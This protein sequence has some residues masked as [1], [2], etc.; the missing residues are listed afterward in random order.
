[1]MVMPI[2]CSVMREVFSQVPSGER[3]GRV[4]PRRDPV[5][6][7]PHRRPALRAGRDHRRDDARPGPGPRRDDRR[8]P[9]HLA[10]ASRSTS[11]SSR[12]AATRCRA[13][14]RCATR[15]RPGSAC[16]RSW[17]PGWRCS[18]SLS[19]STSP[20]RCSSP[21]HARDRAAKHDD[22]R[23][24]RAETGAAASPAATTTDPGSR[25]R[26]AGRPS[27]RR[28]LGAG[29]ARRPDE[30]RRGAG[31]RALHHAAALRA[32]HVAVGPAWVRRR[33]LRRLPRRR[34]PSCV[35]LTDDR[36]AVVDKLMTTLFSTAAA[37]AGLA[38]CSPSSPSP[39]GGAGR[40]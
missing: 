14:S 7:D 12:P 17:P 5:G 40:R 36:P 4:R 20:R 24:T 26:T 25:D 16:R 1:M 27:V 35:S 31:E 10:R 33:H 29:L 23:R 13:S 18:P 2:Q 3:E 11:T 21:G 6:D 19:S 9:D 37:I 38:L 28:S 15:S 22:H 39:C 30:H 8:P 32:A 34:T